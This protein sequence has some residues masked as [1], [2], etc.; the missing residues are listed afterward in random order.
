MW[1]KNIEFFGERCIMKFFFSNG[2]KN[3]LAGWLNKYC[4]VVVSLV[5]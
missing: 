3:G 4:G 1:Y 2:T 5:P